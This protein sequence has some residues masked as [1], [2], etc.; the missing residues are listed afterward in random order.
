MTR[1]VNEDALPA[2]LSHSALLWAALVALEGIALVG[3]FSLTSAE[4]TQ[5]R[6]LLYPFVWI[7]AG[8]WAV[9]N[10]DPS[11][12]NRRHRLLGLLVGVGYF[13]LVM[14]VPGNV[15]TG[16]LVTATD[17]RIAWHAPGWGPLLAFNS[18]W[19]RLYLVP[20]EVVGYAALAYLVYANALALARGT[21]ASVLGIVTCVGCTVP[22]IAPA[23]GL[24]GGPAT[25]LSTTAYQ[26]SYDFGTVLFLVTLGLLYAS[27]RRLL[28]WQ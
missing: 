28:P 8:L 19:V 13:F 12:Q 16:T 10:T 15:G 27:H 9:W 2:G 14:Y 17:L 11:P 23:I 21:I 26:W 5:I 22:I 20:F 25:A 7:N 4:T 6:Y 18:P 24:L 3:Y 1:T